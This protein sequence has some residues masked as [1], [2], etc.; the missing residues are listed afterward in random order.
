MA[1]LDQLIQ[2]ALV[3]FP[4][5]KTSWPVLGWDGAVTELFLRQL[6]N[7][8]YFCKTFNHSGFERDMEMLISE[9]FAGEK[10]ALKVD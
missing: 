2:C 3:Y 8:F 7:I 10:R 9:T 6:F 1:C 4:Q 5:N